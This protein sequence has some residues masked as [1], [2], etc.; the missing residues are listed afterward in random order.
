[1]FMVPPWVQV[2]AE[3]K[4]ANRSA[5]ALGITVMGARLRAVRPSPESSGRREIR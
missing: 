4:M 2:L 5:A 3:D 1:M